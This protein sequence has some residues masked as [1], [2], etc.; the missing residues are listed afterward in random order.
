MQLCDTKTVATSFLKPEFAPRTSYILKIALKLFG[1]L[2][3][4]VTMLF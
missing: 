4:N 3:Y 2:V 1:I